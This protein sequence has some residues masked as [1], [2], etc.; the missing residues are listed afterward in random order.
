MKLTENLYL[1]IVENSGEG[2]W[3]IDE[4]NKTIY[5]NKA[6]AEML[7]LSVEELKTR[8]I[9]EFLYED[10]IEA[11]NF[12]QEERKKGVTIHEVEWRFLRADKLPFWALISANPLYD[13]NGKYFGAV[14][15]FRD[16]TIRK[17]QKTIL[18]SMNNAYTCLSRGDSL[19]EALVELL[20]PVESLIDGMAS[21]ILLLDDEGMHI[22]CG[23]SPSLP[24]EYI[25][26]LVG[27]DIGPTHG[28]CGTAAYT[29]KMVVVSDIENDVLWA[30][31]R[32]L[33][34][35]FGLRACW[36]NPI[37]STDG[38]V[39]G[40]FA[41]YFRKVRDPNDFERSMVQEMTNATSF[42]IEYMKLVSDVEKHLQNEKRHSK[43]IS[44]IAKASK[45]V[46]SSLE[47]A[48]V[49]KK[50]PEFIIDGFADVCYIALATDENKLFAFTVAV[51]DEMQ[52]F[53]QAFKSYKSDPESPHGL[54]RAIREGKS[55]LYC[56]IEDE[57]LD[58]S[59]NEWPKIGTKNPEYV[60]VI[61]KLGLK[62]YMA[63]PIMIRGKPL[64]G[65]LIASFD[66]NRHYSS[67]DLN[68]M[69]EIGRI[70]AVAIDNSLLLKDAKRAIQ[71]RED[72]I[73]IAS[74][75]LRTPLT[76]LQIRIDFLLRHLE[77]VDI[78]KE[79]KEKLGS[80][81]I[82][83]KPDV[84]KFTKLI[85]TLLDVSKFRG[86]KMALIFE[87]VNISQIVADEVFSIQNQF[88]E[89][90][91]PLEINIQGDIFGKIDSLRIQQVVANL[92]MNALK[93]SNKKTVKIILTSDKKI[94]K[95]QIIDHGIGIPAD[96]LERIFKPFERAVSKNHFGGLGLG[97][98]I[99]KQIIEAHDGAISV[100]SK[101]NQGTV[102]Y[103]EFPL[104]K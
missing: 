59:K 36:S 12:H 98:Y 25:E 63:I 72:F 31:Y 6:M 67:H 91:V 29:R 85:D 50:V 10:D 95:I 80:V 26:S 78:P 102:F 24:K 97:L 93:F 99:C 5:A 104:R 35:P 33:A 84:Q 43:E 88:V 100:E 90:D 69:D 60:G 13:D 79:A 23:V 48:E 18:S 11:F 89:K 74:H 38:K 19:E 56:N 82:G 42:L 41:M 77:T 2:I 81:I 73:A 64:G 92:L 46:S 70:C 76:S 65:L 22:K 20:K 54:P 68:L 16:I 57:D 44:L 45:K 7:G 55:I 49:L 66:D 27:L 40:T 103:L 101:P 51:K 86:H 62:S 21:S 1:Q 96:D 4:A 3:I 14:G 32:K 15:Q 17:K 52:D 39:L 9:I 87:K 37:L 30:N 94:V 34:E 83:I 8:S 53:L 47:Y 61:R 71:N 28:S 58:L 75:E